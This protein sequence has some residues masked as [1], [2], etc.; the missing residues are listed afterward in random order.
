VNSLR[1]RAMPVV[2]TF[3]LFGTAADVP[4]NTAADADEFTEPFAGVAFARTDWQFAGTL[5]AA[6][7]APRWRVRGALGKGLNLTSRVK[8]VL[9]V[10]AGAT[11]QDGPR[12]R[13][14]EIGGAKAVP[15]LEY[16]ASPGAHL[17]IGKAELIESTN[18]WHA[19]GL[20][21][22][23]WFVPQP[24]AFIHYAASWDDPAG[25]NNFFVKP[26]GTAWRGAAGIGLGWRVGLPEP[27]VFWRIEMA[28]P[29]GPESGSPTLNFTLG[30]GFDLV[31]R[32]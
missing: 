11:R 30:R 31:G 23:D 16:G 13:K 29:V 12:Q 22:P 32:L 24:T 6:G 8:A 14:F 25:R 27:D 2:T 3:S 20:H 4:P 17:L 18:L 26:P 5:D 10:E 21:R 9:Q 7:D 19:L 28:W 1:E 15:S